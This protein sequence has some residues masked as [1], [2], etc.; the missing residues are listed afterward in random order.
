MKI[1]VNYNKPIVFDADAITILSENKDWLK[2]VPENSIFTPHPKEFE[3]LFG[4]SENDYIRT[5]TQIKFAYK[6]SSYI[7]LKGAHTIIATPEGKCFINSTGNP[8]M[9]TGGS[10]D[11]LTGIIVSLLAQG[12][13]PKDASIIGVYI[14]GLSGDIAVKE[15]GEE[16]LIASDL[17]KNI[18]F[19]DL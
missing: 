1:I 17:I 12:Y 8:G 2:K 3:Q 7:I 19:K 18:N 15:K 10:G 13:S 9:A 11:V 16:A 14:H 4:K 5:K 6:L